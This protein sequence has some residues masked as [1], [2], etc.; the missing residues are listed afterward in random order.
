MKFPKNSESTTAT[1]RFIWKIKK[2]YNV[3]RANKIMILSQRVKSTL[4]N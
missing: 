2:F 3:L 1:Y 4:V